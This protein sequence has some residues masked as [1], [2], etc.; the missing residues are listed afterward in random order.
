[1]KISVI[2]P[3]H[4]E[5]EI[6]EKTI[7]KTYEVLTRNKYDYEIIVVDDNSDDKT[8]KILNKLSK[9]NKRIRS[10]HKKYRN[11]GPTGLGSAIKFGIKYCSGDIVVPL[12]GDLSDNPNDI[13]K[14]IKK[15]KEGYDVVCG[16]RFIAGSKII[17]YPKIKMLCNRFYNRLFAFLFFLDV[18]D[19]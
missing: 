4:N 14:L 12:M 11:K 17:G 2:I 5:E 15:I 13:P 16:S 19:I 8:E 6:I 7:K 10:F 3:V 18:E 9:R 1:M